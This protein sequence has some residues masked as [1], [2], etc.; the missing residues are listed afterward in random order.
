[1]KNQAE[2]LGRGFNCNR[3]NDAG[4]VCVSWI[5]PRFIGQVYL[6]WIIF[7]ALGPRWFTKMND[8]RH[9]YAIE[10]KLD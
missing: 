10:I 5:D 4:H 6:G 9:E 7:E 1:M 2:D 8:K 3:V